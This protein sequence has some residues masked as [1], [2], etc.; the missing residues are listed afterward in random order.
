MTPEL[1]QEILI[2]SLLF[3]PIHIGVKED[4]KTKTTGMV[5]RPINFVVVK[6]LKWSK[7][8]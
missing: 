1:R 6:K 4:K 8:E 5:S 3:D 2:K 7:K